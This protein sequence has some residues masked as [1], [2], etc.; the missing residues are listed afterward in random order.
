MM[1][2]LTN[3]ANE[4]V[5]GGAVALLTTCYVVFK[6]IKSDTVEIANQK[7]EINIINI[8]TKQRDDYVAMSDKY[9]ES[10]IATEKEIREIKNILQS[11]EFEKIKL[12]E[13]LDKKDSELDLLRQIISYLK[14]TVAVARELIDTNDQTNQ[15]T[16]NINQD[17]QI[18]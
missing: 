5:I 15:N 18:N 7:A 11:L 4:E 14:D 9:R 1:V 10:L 17:D 2:D 13:K 6:K 8:L 12:I 3:L 16:D